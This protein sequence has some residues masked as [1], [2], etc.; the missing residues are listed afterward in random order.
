MCLIMI[1][2]YTFIYVHNVYVHLNRKSEQLKWTADLTVVVVVVVVV[3]VLSILCGLGRRYVD[4][5][6]CKRVYHVWK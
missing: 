1:I 6:F 4:C 3:V 5:K 2:T